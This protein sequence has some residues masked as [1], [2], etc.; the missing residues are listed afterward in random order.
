MATIYGNTVSYDSGKYRLKVVWSCSDSGIFFI[1]YIEI[2]D[3]FAQAHTVK[4][5]WT[6]R[7]DAWTGDKKRKAKQTVAPWD[8]NRGYYGGA[9]LSIWCKCGSGGLSQVTLTSTVVPWRPGVSAAFSNDNRISI[10][11]SGSASA[12]KP[13]NTV[14]L[15][16]QTEYESANWEQLASWAPGGASYTYYFDDQTTARGSKYRYRVNAT[17]QAGASGESYTDW[18]YTNPPDISEVAHVRN[19]NYSCTI[20]WKRS[21][22]HI[23]RGL[24]TGFAIERSVSGG[25]WATIAYTGVGD[26]QSDTMSYT[27]NSCAPDNYYRYRVKPMNARGASRNA[28]PDGGTDATYNTPAAP[29]SVTAVY[30]SSN[31]GSLTLRNTTKTGTELEIE[32]CEDGVN[33]IQIDSVEEGGAPCVTY[34]DVRP[35]SGTS[36]QY[37]CRNARDELPTGER[38]SA[39]A[40]SN[41][42]STLRIPSPP[43]LTMPVSGT[44][45]ML[46]SAS[47]RLTWVHNPNDGTPQEAAEI[48]YRVNGTYAGSATTGSSSYYDLAIDPSVFSANDQVTWRVRTKGAHATYSDWSSYMDFKLFARPGIRFTSPDNGSVIT[49][50]PISLG[51]DYEDLSGRLVSLTLNIVQKQTVLKSIDIPVGSGTSGAYSYSLAEYLFDNEE[52]YQLETVALSSTGL[53][54][55]D[56]IAVSIDYVPVRLADSFFIIAETDPDTGYVS[57]RA[58]TDTSPV[59]TPG[60]P[61]EE[62][63]VD[64]PVEIAYLYRVYKGKRT[65]LLSG[66]KDGDTFVDKYAPLNAEYTYELLEIAES[67]QISIISIGNTVRSNLWFTY[68]GT[69]NIARAQWEPSGSVSLGRPEKKQVRYSGRRFP[70]T[71][72]SD[73]MEETYKFSAVIINREDLD[74]FRK[75]MEDGGQ[76]VWK[77]A[78]GDVYKADFDFSYSADY[79]ESE[80]TWKCSL[81]VTRIESEDL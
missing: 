10:T 70:V 11:V 77:S 75:L 6:G 50:L 55:T 8:S 23:D 1:P 3:A 19:S 53:T 65:L 35:I 22:Q 78:D 67:G 42:V 51:W 7:G 26:I 73:A 49:N 4:I 62:I 79:V 24:I 46:D 68:W 21:T 29:A 9:S 5:N 43:T 63:Y 18:V 30:N 41:V 58:E 14:T 44:P 61:D 2:T 20:S 66:I 40:Y 36:V 13:A 80:I 31:Q 16:R 57:L 48:Q 28:Y 72:D 25:S 74:A 37:R 33:W 47:V 17:N 27:D 69:E 81:D 12:V 39:W 76:G 32:R 52:N 64:S 15:E 59:P 60:D 45:V 54:A 38:Y 34:T 71:Y 56:S